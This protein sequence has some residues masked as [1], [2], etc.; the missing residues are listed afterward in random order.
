M[1]FLIVSIFLNA[2]LIVSFKAVER[3]GIPLLQAIVVN[4]VTCVVTGLM[5][6][7]AL[8]LNKE[9]AQQPWFLWAVLMGVLF[10]SLFNL[11]GF[12]AQRIG[13]AVASVV[14]KLSLVIPFLFSIYLYAEPLTLLKAGGV[15]LALVAVV[16]ISWP[17]TAVNEKSSLPHLL[18][19]L[20]PV[21]LF[22]STGLL[23]TLVKY[24]EHRFLSSRNSDAYLVAAFAA[25]AVIG[26]AF[27]LAL[28]VRG[29]QKFHSGALVAGVAIGVPN[30][31]SM[32]SLVKA[33][34]HYPGRSSVII[35]V[36]NMGIV[37]CSAVLAYFIFGERLTA[38]NRLGLLLS[39]VAIAL[40]AFG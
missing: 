20:I 15:L 9:T 21:I 28:I 11:I 33:L 23:D 17:Q 25:A 22:V 18:R 26:L 35:P 36:N 16:C 40:L 4:Y 5:M 6:Q 39:F 7:G 24:V 19:L 2:Y 37:L 30:Y 10:I 8:P 27:M 12:T 34:Q 38:L 14:T 31:F 1:I 32:W 29:R 13:V 3:Y